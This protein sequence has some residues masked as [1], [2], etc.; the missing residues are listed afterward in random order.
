MQDDRATSGPGVVRA[1]AGSVTAWA[2]RAHARL[3]NFK[4]FEAGSLGSGAISEAAITSKLL[5]LSPQR[6][7]RNSRC[8]NV[9][10]GEGLNFSRSC[11]TRLRAEVGSLGRGGFS[12]A[13]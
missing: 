1:V 5:T 11:G 10:K 4:L 2:G 13:A 12:E 3:F 6:T 9:G 8:E 7:L